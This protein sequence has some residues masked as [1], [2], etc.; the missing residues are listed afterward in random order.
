M[1]FTFFKEDLITST[2]PNYLNLSK[3]N[4]N[5]MDINNVIELISNIRSLKAELKIVC[6]W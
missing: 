1:A 2:W 6:V 3:F 5:Q 4:K